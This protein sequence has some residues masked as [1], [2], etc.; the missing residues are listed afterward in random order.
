MQGISDD[1]NK[2][3]ARSDRT[4]TAACSVGVDWAM[5]SIVAPSI[6]FGIALEAARVLVDM[7]SI[8]D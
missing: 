5:M 1:L 7:G 2:C 8:L 4:S 6:T 3:I